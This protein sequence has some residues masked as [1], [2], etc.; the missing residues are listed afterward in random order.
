MLKECIDRIV[1]LAMPTISKIEGRQYSDKSLVPIL[2]PLD[3]SE[4]VST[5][6]GF[7]ELIK[8]SINGHQGAECYIH[9]ESPQ[10]V[11]LNEYICNDWG[12]RQRHLKAEL[13]G[14]M[15]SFQY[16]QFIGQE[17]FIIGLM[18][19]FDDTHDRDALVKQVSSIEGN[20]VD[21]SEDDGIS[22]R[23]TTKRG[24]ALKEQEIIKRIVRLA[25]YRTFREIDQPVSEFIFRVKKTDDGPKLALFEADGGKWR[26]EAVQSIKCWLEAR[27]EDITVAA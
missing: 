24:L 9:V 11:S 19:L 18:S 16:G 4:T 21:I 2:D 23:V 26:L 5:L 8:H 7:V 14:V 17:A 20:D 12:K 6:T 27:V 10:I 15:Q 1:A 22:Q 25:P 3:D 13:P